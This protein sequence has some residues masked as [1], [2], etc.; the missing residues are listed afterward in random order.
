M[1]IE[2]LHSCSK[3]N[4]YWS[5]LPRNSQNR[6]IKWPEVLS[7]CSFFSQIEHSADVNVVFVQHKRAIHS[8]GSLVHL[9]PST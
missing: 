2:A 3:C 6:I 7:Q 1:G 4:F 9:M 5:V 8:N